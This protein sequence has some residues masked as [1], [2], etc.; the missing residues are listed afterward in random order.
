[1]LYLDLRVELTVPLIRELRGVQRTIGEDPQ[2]ATKLMEFC[3]VGMGR[4]L[5]YYKDNRGYGPIEA[6]AH[7]HGRR[8]YTRHKDFDLLIPHELIKVLRDRK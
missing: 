7:D 2:E 5:E 6:V 1:M 4:F 8:T 3:A